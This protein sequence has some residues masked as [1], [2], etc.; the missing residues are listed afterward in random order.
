MRLAEA[1]ANATAEEIAAALA[2]GK[3]VLY[4]VGRPPSPDHPVTRSSVL[5]EYEF[6][7]PA[8]AGPSPAFA[9][10]PTPAKSVGTPGWARAFGADGAVVADFSVGPG[11]TDVKID[12]VSAT[13]GFPLKVLTIALT[14]PAENASWDKTEYGHVYLTG[15][16]NPWRKV[17]VRG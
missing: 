8:F 15:S 13:P 2:G 5:A 6:S 14:L 1:F 17:S 10:N 9:A 3:L 16:E 4:S 12:G 11:S 7:S